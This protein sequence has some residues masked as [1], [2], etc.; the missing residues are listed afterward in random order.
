AEDGRN[1]AGSGAVIQDVRRL[2]RLQ[3]QIDLDRV[4][5]VGPDA[6]PGVVEGESPLVVLLD[7]FL[8]LIERQWSAGPHAAGEQVLYQ[9][10]PAGPES[11]PQ[12]LRGVP[13]VTAE[14]P[15]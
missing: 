7:D 5:L 3:L 11:Q 13:Q 9:H 2:A 4:P 15:A 1:G 12:V 8:E 6:R 10:P 14:E